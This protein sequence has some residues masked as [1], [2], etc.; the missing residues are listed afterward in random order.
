MLFPYFL[1]KPGCW[2]ACLV[3]FLA[4]MPLLSPCPL[5]KMCSPSCPLCAFPAQLIPTQH[6]SWAQLFPTPENL[7]WPLPPPDLGRCSKPWYV[8]CLYK[9]YKSVTCCLLTDN[10]CLFLCLSH[11]ESGAVCDSIPI[12][13]TYEHACFTLSIQQICVVQGIKYPW[14]IKTKLTAAQEHQECNPCSGKGF[15][16]WIQNDCH[17]WLVR[18]EREKQALGAL[19]SESSSE[20][21]LLIT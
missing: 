10:S 2:T 11:L 17:S 9:Q 14:W 16:L 20:Q 19:I 6:W 12:P 13:C 8:L 18:S 1:A 21:L 15:S 3:L 7:S 4:S 5:P